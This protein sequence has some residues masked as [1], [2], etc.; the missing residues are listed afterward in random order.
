MAC[1]SLPTHR[2]RVDNTHKPPCHRTRLLGHNAI[3]PQQAIRGSASASQHR[4]KHLSSY[5]LG[6]ALPRLLRVVRPV[7]TKRRLPRIDNARIK[8]MHL[9]VVSMLRLDGGNDR[10]ATVGHMFQVFGQ[11]VVVLFPPIEM[12]VAQETDHI[13][14]ARGRWLEDESGLSELRGIWLAR[15]RRGQQSKHALLPV[16]ASCVARLMPW[17]LWNWRL[18][19]VVW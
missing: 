7:T 10:P 2:D 5:L 17:A 18:M 15:A 16:T 13:V 12:L 11:R 6:L 19:L 3:P 9:R 4:S 14:G 1:H 8:R